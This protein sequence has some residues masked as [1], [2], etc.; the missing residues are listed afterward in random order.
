[1]GIR[2]SLL[3]KVTLA[4]ILSGQLGIVLTYVLRL[5]KKLVRI[6]YQLYENGGSSMKDQMNDTREDLTHLKTDFLV[7]KAKLGE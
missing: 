1:M 3:D 2:V 4:V 5:E 6:E 7:L